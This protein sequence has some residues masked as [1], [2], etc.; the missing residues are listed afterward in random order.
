AAIY[1]QQQKWGTLDGKNRYIKSRGFEVEANFQPNKQ[2]FATISYSYFDSRQRYAGFLADS[3]VYD[4]RLGS[5][6]P[7]TPDFPSISQEF[8]T[9]GMPKH[10]V[11]FLLNYKFTPA[12]SASI[13]TVWTGEIVTSLVGQGVSGFGVPV[14]LSANKIPRQYTTD[15]TLAYTWRSWNARLALMN[16]TNQKNWSAP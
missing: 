6:V 1:D 12:F 16:V 5:A 4:K 3:I 9:P 13:G 10:L 7:F 15:V 8:Q 2:L 11:N 14:V